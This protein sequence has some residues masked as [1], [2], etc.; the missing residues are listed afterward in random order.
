MNI[1]RLLNLICIVVGGSIAIY[2]QA[3][4]QQNTY[5]LIGG[6]VLLVFGIYRT[7][8][9]IPSKFDKEEESFIKTEKEDEI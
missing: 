7:S 8:R 5:I 4:E 1:S 3:Q 2:A 9:N 6:I